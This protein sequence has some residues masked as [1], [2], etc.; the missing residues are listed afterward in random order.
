MNK[1]LLQSM[2]P[3]QQLLIPFLEILKRFLY[4]NKQLLQSMKHL[5]QLLISFLEI[6]KPFLYMKEQLL[7]TLQFW[8]LVFR[9]KRV[10]SVNTKERGDKT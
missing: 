3:L 7:Q 9:V 2:K 5:Q 10:T 6:L 4:M 1:Q 8:Q